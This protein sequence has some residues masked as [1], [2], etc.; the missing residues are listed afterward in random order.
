MNEPIVKW[1]LFYRMSRAKG[2]V[3]IGPT[4]WTMFGLYDQ[5]DEAMNRGNDFIRQQGYETSI[6][7]VVIERPTDPFADA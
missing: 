6:A 7:K 4:D 2:L 3:S 1:A 5:W